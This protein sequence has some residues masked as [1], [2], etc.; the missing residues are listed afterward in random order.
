MKLKFL[1][2][3]IR[4]SSYLFYGIFFQCLFMG[5]LMAKESEGQNNKSITEI[6]ISIEAQNQSLYRVLENIGNRTG[7]QFNYH[8]NNISLKRVSVSYENEPLISVLEDIARQTSLGFKRV[9]DV[10]AV[11]SRFSSSN[12]N[13]SEEIKDISQTTIS[14][15]VISSEDNEPLPGVSIII[16]GTNIGTTTD[17]D[18]NYSLN[19]TSDDTF[20]FSYIGFIT[21]EINIGNQNEVNIELQPDLEQ[22]EE[23]VV[24]GYG[25][26]SKGQLTGAVSSLKSDKITV[27]PLNSTV[28][29]LA[30]QLPGLKFKQESGM[31]GSD[32]ANISIRGFGNALVIVDGVQR[33]FNSLDPNQIESISIL[34]DGA[35]SIYGARAGNGVIIVTTKR[36]TV[37]K[38]EISFN[39]SWTA[40]GVT[41]IVK[42][43]SSGQRAEMAREGHIQAG[44]DPSTAPYTQEAIDKYYA[45]DD[46]AYPNTDWYKFTFREWAPQQNYNLS[47]RGGSENIKYYG[48]LG[49][50]DQETIIKKNGGN[51]SR[52]N[53]QSNI[54]AAITKDLSVVLDLSM[55]FENRL[56]PGRGIG[57]GSQNGNGNYVWDD[58][59][60]TQPFYPAQLPDPTKVTYAAIPT[61]NVYAASNMDI[62]G[63]NDNKRRNILGNIKLV[64]D[65]PFVEG[66][67]ASALVN[68][69][70]TDDYTKQF[71]KP[72]D[73]WEYNTTLDEYSVVGG[74]SQSSIGEYMGRSDMLTKQ[75]SVKYD[76]SLNDHSISAMALYESI[77]TKSNNF[78]ASRQNLLT[79]E[80]QQLYIGDP[81]TQANNGSA[82][83]MG[84]KSWVGRAE[85]SFKRRYLL[86]GIFRADA[87]AK[88]PEDSRWGYF[89][90]V[91]AGWVISEEGFMNAVEPLNFLKVRASV[92]QSGNDGVGNFQYLSGYS[93]L[94]SV[95]MDEGNIGGLYITGLANPTLTW[96]KMTIYN[97]GLDFGLWNDKIY[98]TA[99]IF[100]RDRTGIPGR[101]VVSLPST[102]GANLPLENLNDLE[103]RGFELSLGT[104]KTTG[105][106]TY[107]ISGNLTYARAKWVKFDEPEFEDEDQKRLNQRTGQ[108]TDRITGYVSDELFTTQEEIDALPYIYEALGDNSS[109]RPGD[110][111]Y[112]DLNNDGVLNWK[113]QTSIGNNSN[114]NWIFALNSA[115]QYKGISLIT[116]FQG[117]TG[118]STYVGV[119]YFPTEVTYKLRWTEENNNANALIPRLGGS[120]SN[121][122]LSDNNLR[123]VTY[124][125]LK[126]ASLGYD[127]PSSLLDPIGLKKAKVYVAGTNIFTLSSISDFGVDPEVQSGR[128]LQVY[129]QQRTYSVGLNI[130]F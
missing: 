96:E 82:S 108:Y 29:T 129:P 55:T 78:G 69:L 109:L 126:T 52:Y 47:V 121:G 116:N 112:L 115:I 70:T 122:W 37:Q 85:Y 120:P 73:F 127:L 43:A 32:A 68:Y 76:R 11:N 44:N 83:E 41:K 62:F 57:N 61:G 18:G 113:D 66:L 100:K 84:R 48:Y 107:N 104:K 28:N 13:V 67:Q 14:G 1:R 71:R 99:E 33:D 118:Y 128:S 7:F 88:F 98:G 30:G 51:Y 124:L 49:Y 94:R 87:S 17:L 59:Y 34:K 10:I 93:S 31:P 26:Q 16:K 3:L 102:F 38:P 15:K 9:N 117:A 79:T 2:Q 110:I 4:M 89:P 130:T 90:S 42:P 46:P 123:S 81:T 6:Y 64:Y 22:L 5:L 53:V 36:G 20:Q 39:T 114:P 27:A 125:R 40:Q 106:F 63:Y 60:T 58:L 8:N 92:G 23:V 86:Q 75:Y 74:F 111:K 103:D 54:D 80:I 91:S 35:A 119:S 50:G 12:N 25:T 72:Y 97:L 105:D 101:R 95:I 56:F 21:Q 45:G 77:D 19:A 24:V 65:I